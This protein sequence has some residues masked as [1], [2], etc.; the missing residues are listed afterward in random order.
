MKNSNNKKF[1]VSAMIMLMIAMYGVVPLPS[2]VSA[3]DSL[4]DAKDL[5]GDSDVSQ[6]TEHSVTFT[7][8]TAIP[9]GG[10]IGV[11]FPAAFGNLVVGGVV[12]PA[13]F[14]RSVPFTHS[15]FCTANG[16]P[17]PAGAQEIFVAFVDNP[18]TAGVQYIK[19]TTYD[20]GGNP[21]LERATVA[22]FIIEDILMT[23]RVESTLDFTISG[24]AAAQTVNGVTCD[25]TTTATT[26]DF[27]TLAVD[28]NKAVCQELTV[29]TNADDGYTVTVEQ[30]DELT[31]DSGSNINSFNNAADGT[32]TVVAA[33]WAN[34]ANTLD[35]Y[36]TY[37]HMG[38][39]SDD[40]DLNSLGTYNSFA[41]GDTDTALQYAGLNDDDP[42]AV[43]HHDGPADGSTQNK[44]IARVLYQAR[45]A[46]LQEAGDYENT[47]T[48]I[49]TP[50]Y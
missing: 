47:L 38:L 41:V 24:V 45:I 20:V 26:T 25:V 30:D 15:A 29:T 6:T 22:V 50:I 8:G 46:S 10:I 35:S 43:M 27:G 48:Y 16:A 21:V 23:A 1:F 3:I 5:I 31:S 33:P 44:G 12:C 18:A 11:E 39:T 19:I 2:K 40:A 32:G 36:N 28:T 9:D 4:S 14:V 42:M 17:I 13:G 34:P 7:T 37:G 49:V